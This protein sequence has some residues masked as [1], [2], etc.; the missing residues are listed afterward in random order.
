MFGEDA[1]E[2]TQ[3]FDN[4]K[5]GD[6]VDA[7]GSSDDYNI[8]HWGKTRIRLRGSDKALVFQGRWYDPDNVSKNKWGDKDSTL[9]NGS[10][11]SLDIQFSFKTQ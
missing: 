7:D 5:T 11:M 4:N 1:I 3:F 6:F 10:R 8:E 2:N 9:K